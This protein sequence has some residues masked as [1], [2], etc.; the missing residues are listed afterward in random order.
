MFNYTKYRVKVKGFQKSC[1]LIVYLTPSFALSLWAK[2]LKG[3]PYLM[4]DLLIGYISFKIYP[5]T[6]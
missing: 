5:S 6:E 2:A 3:K 4:R 1:K